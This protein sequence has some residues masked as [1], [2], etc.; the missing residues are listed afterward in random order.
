MRSAFSNVETRRI[1]GEQIEFLKIMHGFIG[2]NKDNL[3]CFT[4]LRTIAELADIRPYFNFNKMLLQVIIIIIII[5]IIIFI[6]TLGPQNNQHK[7]KKK[8]K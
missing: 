7:H 8:K 2:L 1:G 3:L 5:I 4:E 6:R